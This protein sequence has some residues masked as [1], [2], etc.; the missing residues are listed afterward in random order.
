MEEIKT[1][2]K[3]F[4]N[5]KFKL[6]YIVFQKEQ[7][8][9]IILEELKL[10]LDE[11]RKISIDEFHAWFF[12]SEIYYKNKIDAIWAIEYFNSLLILNNLISE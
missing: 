4:F 9:L 2:L 7:S 1:K 6:Y 3:I 8:D 11:Y 12:R 10:T 5:T